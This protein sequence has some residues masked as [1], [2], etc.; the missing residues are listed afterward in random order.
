[1]NY[2]RAFR[3]IRSAKNLTMAELAVTLSVHESYISLIES[4]KRSP[5]RR[6][7]ERLSPSLGVPVHLF[8]LLASDAEDLRHVGP[9]SAQEIG[10][11]L[12]NLLP[13]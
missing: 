5:G 10:K 1:M 4:G 7:V 8:D 13:D 3:L 2:A 6:L 11:L 9:E 12:L